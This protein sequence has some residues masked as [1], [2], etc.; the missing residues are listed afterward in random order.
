MGATFVVV[1]TPCVIGNAVSVFTGGVVVMDLV[2]RRT[3]SLGPSL[4]AKGLGN[5]P[6][7]GKPTSSDF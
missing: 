5:I 6:F 3:M 4:V 1:G 7:V 2:I